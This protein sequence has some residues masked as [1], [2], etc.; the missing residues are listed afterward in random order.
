M[1][2][3]NNTLPLTAISVS[4]IAALF[5]Y[6]LPLQGGLAFWRPPFVLLVTVYWLIVQPQHVGITFV[7]FSG[8]LLDLLYGNVIGQNALAQEDLERHGDALL[9]EMG[10]DSQEQPP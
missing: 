4:L 8:L 9:C 7:W 1:P 5:L 3:G 10:L 2:R 6:S